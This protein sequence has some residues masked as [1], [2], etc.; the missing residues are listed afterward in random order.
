M[1]TFEIKAGDHYVIYRCPTNECNHR[2]A[3]I[4]DGLLVSTREAPYCMPK[5]QMSQEVFDSHFADED[6]YGPR[7]RMVVEVE[8][9][10]SKGLNWLLETLA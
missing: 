3:W 10:L 5:G 9:V 2:E 8:S 4:V 7:V 1:A 6:P